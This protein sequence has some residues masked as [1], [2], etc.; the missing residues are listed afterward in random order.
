MLPAQ[1]GLDAGNAVALKVALGLI[2]QD[3]LVALERPA[4]AGFQHQ[5][6]DRLG[7]DL[8]G[9]QQT[10]VAAGFLGG[11]HRSFGV[12]GERDLVV[13]VGGKQRGADA[14][15]HAAFLTVERQRLDY[16][17][18]N[19]ARQV[20]NLVAV[21]NLGQQ[22]DELIAADAR[23]EVASTDALADAAGDFDQQRISGQMA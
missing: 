11:V 15:S 16:G 1:Q 4:Q 7:L 21:G 17:G 8:R 22:N 3:E 19:P 6:L 2:V 12:L 5:P 10:R 20:G 14:G 18:Q 23:D 9:M 13:G